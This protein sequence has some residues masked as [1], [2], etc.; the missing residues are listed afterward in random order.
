MNK[1]ISILVLIICLIIQVKINTLTSHANSVIYPEEYKNPRFLDESINYCFIH[2]ET[3]N[4]CG[5]AS[6]QMVLKYLNVLPLPNQSTLANEMNTTI[7]KYTYAN[8]MH[9]PFKKRGFKYYNYTAPSF[10]IA[11]SNLR[12][13]ISKN[14]PI[15]ILTWYDLSH[16][17]GHYRVVIGYNYSGI[18]VHD[19]WDG[20]NKFLNN[21]I[22]EDL[23]M[24]S[25]FWSL[26][27]LERPYFNLSIRITDIFN[28]PI[29]NLKVFL[30]NKVSISKLTDSNGI[31]IF[32]EL[33]IG[34]Y[35][36]KY[37]SYFKDETETLI[38]T[39]S[40]NK[41]YKIISLNNLI[42]IIILILFTLICF[43]IFIT[44]KFFT[45]ANAFINKFQLY[46]LMAQVLP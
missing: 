40:I 42:I 34:V 10:K 4:S 13:N 9:I 17:N 14:F 33:P 12:G 23:W 29:K 35:E 24:Y 6:I 36:L 26:I 43:I 45:H 5:P 41:E 19:P 25:N 20:P 8:Y 15:I 2:Q 32:E 16:K 44:S 7:H 39:K 18:F 37:N 1:R 46:F 30:I 31:A 27:I 38:L 22:L 3:T 21:S 28:F 11:L